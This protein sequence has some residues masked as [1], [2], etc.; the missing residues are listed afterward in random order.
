MIM[1]SPFEFFLIG[2]GIA[3]FVGVY[4]VNYLSK[5]EGREKR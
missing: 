1:I 5:R 3:A 4:A 2:L